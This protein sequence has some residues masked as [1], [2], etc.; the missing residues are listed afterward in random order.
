[1]APP[2][3]V[4]PYL[5]ALEPY[6]C[7]KRRLRYIETTMT[8]YVALLHGI[9]V[10]G[11]NLIKMTDLKACFEALGFEDVSTYI[12]SGNVLFS[13]G[14]S[15]QANLT[16]LIEEALSKAFNYKSRVVVRSQKEIKDI[17]ARTPRGF[18]SDPDTYRYYVIFLK[19]PMRTVKAMK[20][21]STRP[22]PGRACFTFRY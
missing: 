3:W 21:A 22:L 5:V 11:K 6:T 12:Q 2:T 14:R 19:E 8:R 13:T 4:E 17:V 20:S 18:G 10:G 16:K 1:M 7:P 9:N 15:D